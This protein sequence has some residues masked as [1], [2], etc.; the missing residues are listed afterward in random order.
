MNSYDMFI[1]QESETVT[2]N[3]TVSRLYEVLNKGLATF[4]NN[5]ADLQ[6]ACR[7][8]TGLSD[9]FIVNDSVVEYN[10]A[11][12]DYL[13]VDYENLD[14]GTIAVVSIDLL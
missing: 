11:N 14:N 4:Y 1:Q 6:N 7:E 12:V 8:L 3:E 2:G 9:W 10:I 13:V 5:V